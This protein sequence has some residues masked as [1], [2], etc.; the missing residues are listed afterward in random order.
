MDTPK[1]LFKVFIRKG[2]VHSLSDN[3]NSKIS[4]KVQNEA[5]TNLSC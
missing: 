2:I 4:I 3:C 5:I 1:D